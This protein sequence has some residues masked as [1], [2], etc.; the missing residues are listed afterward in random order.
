[1]KAYSFE[2]PAHALEKIISWIT[3]DNPD[4]PLGNHKRGGGKTG[5]GWLTQAV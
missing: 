5:E 3:A 4:N 2:N 1:M